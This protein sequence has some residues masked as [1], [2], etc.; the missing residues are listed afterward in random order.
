MTNHLFRV[1]FD[2]IST[3]HVYVMAMV[4]VMEMEMEIL[5]VMVM[6][7]VIVMEMVVMVREYVV[8]ILTPPLNPVSK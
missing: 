6:V 8:Q 7:V 4:I 5:T 1:G 3:R 2:L